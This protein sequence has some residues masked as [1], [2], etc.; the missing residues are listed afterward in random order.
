M[1]SPLSLLQYCWGSV[2][3]M[4]DGW[5][6]IICTAVYTSTA[7]AVVYLTYGLSHLAVDLTHRPNWVYDTKIQK[8]PYQQEGGRAGPPLSKVAFWVAV[9]L[10][11]SVPLGLVL[12]CVIFGPLRVERELPGAWEFAR[13]AFIS[14]L[15]TEPGFYYTHRLFHHPKFYW[16]HKQHHEFHSPIALCTLY[17]SP[18]EVALGN[19]IAV[20]TGPFICNSHLFTLV[21]LSPIGVLSSM[22]DHTGYSFWHGQHGLVSQPD[23]HD[24]HHSANC[25]N[26][27][28]IGILDWLHGTDKAWLKAREEAKQRANSRAPSVHRAL[29]NGAA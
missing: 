10:F 25:G 11:V 21:V 28:I 20:T 8:V 27:G 18:I 24:F 1:L 15:L 4:T 9:S 14:L 3:D 29:T 7:V 26:Y 23:F 6:P 5:D 17:A 13:D 19:I 12:L 22:R 2:L 16:I